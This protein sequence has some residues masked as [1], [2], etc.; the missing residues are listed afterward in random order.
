MLSPIPGPSIPSSQFVSVLLSNASNG[1][2]ET[3]LACLSSDDALADSIYASWILLK[4]TEDS[5]TREA[6]I[7]DAG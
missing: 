2:L 5:L 1:S 7:A 4:S 6:V 3:P